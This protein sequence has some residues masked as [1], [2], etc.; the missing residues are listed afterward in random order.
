MAEGGGFDGGRPGTSCLKEEAKM[1]SP[2]STAA[3]AGS[4]NAGNDGLGWVFVVASR[5]EKIR[6]LLLWRLASFLCDFEDDEF[7]WLEWCK[8]YHD[9]DKTCRLVGG[10]RGLSPAFDEI[11]ILRLGPLKGPLPK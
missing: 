9:V 4:T 11:G 5:T 6:P 8:P 10:G 2:L 7:G 1:D 3:G